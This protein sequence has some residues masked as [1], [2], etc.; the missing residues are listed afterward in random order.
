MANSPDHYG[1][2][3]EVGNF[4]RSKDLNFH[5]GNAIKYIC[6]ANHKGDKESD[7]RKAIHYLENELIHT[8]NTNGSGGGIPHSLQ[9]YDEWESEADSKGFD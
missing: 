2:N 1:N 3:W 8:T 9:S 5:L 6:R 4:I 7:L